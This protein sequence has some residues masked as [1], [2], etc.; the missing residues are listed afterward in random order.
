MSL[1]RGTVDSAALGALW[2]VGKPPPP[3]YFHSQALRLQLGIRPTWSSRPNREEMVIV[4]IPNISPTSIPIVME[5]GG[6]A[7]RLNP[8]AAVGVRWP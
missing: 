7:Y 6:P 5:G 2:D 1:S 8:E 3:D 4:N